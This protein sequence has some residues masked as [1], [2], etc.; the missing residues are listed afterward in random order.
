[1]QTFTLPLA[2]EQ[3]WRAPSAER[4]SIRC[5]RGLLW[6]TVHGE[7]QD[8]L[9]HEG[10][11]LVLERPREALVGAIETALLQVEM[12]GEDRALVA[13]AEAASGFLRRFAYWVWARPVGLVA[14]VRS[15]NRSRHESRLV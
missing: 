15:V 13:M 12:V 9:L 3:H 11:V 4:V 1:M 2:P 5:E 6:V 7:A 8:Y 10:D 14:P